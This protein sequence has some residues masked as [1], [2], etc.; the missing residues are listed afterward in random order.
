MHAICRITF[1]SILLKLFMSKN[2]NNNY[3]YFLD[4]NNLSKI[5]DKV[6]LHMTCIKQGLL[7]ILL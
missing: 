1:S 3:C 4:I 7:L 2:S 5:E 6:I